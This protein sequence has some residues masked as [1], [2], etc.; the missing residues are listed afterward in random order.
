MNSN[1]TGAGLTILR[2]LIDWPLFFI[3]VFIYHLSISEDIAVA[4]KR[5]NIILIAGYIISILFYFVNIFTSTIVRGDFIKNIALKNGQESL[6]PGPVFIVLV[7]FILCY[8]Y[9]ALCSFVKKQETERKQSPILALVF[10][11]LTVLVI[12]VAY[13]QRITSF[14]FYSN[15]GL[16]VFGLIIIYSLIRENLFLGESQKLDKLFV[17]KTVGVFL[18]SFI[19]LGVYFIFNKKLNLHDF[20]Y[21]NAL[22][23]LVLMSHS[24]YDWLSTFVNDVIFNFS[25]GLSLVNDAEISNI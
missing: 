15:L 24:F 18:I 5:S 14:C 7:V 6:Q 8:I 4:K 16:I 19:Y 12:V 9:L 13:Y 21:L 10:Y 2:I 11:A 1:F 3:P 25:S 17:Y 23:F 20:T 22:L